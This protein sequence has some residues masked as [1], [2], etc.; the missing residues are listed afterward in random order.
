MAMVLVCT[1]VQ[2]IKLELW[3]PMSMELQIVDDSPYVARVCNLA[4]KGVE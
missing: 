2:C 1:Q 4:V 3:S